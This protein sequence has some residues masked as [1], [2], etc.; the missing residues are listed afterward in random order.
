MGKDDTGER[1]E[2]LELDQHPT[3]H[4]FYVASQ[5]HP[6][7]K[8]RPGKPTPL[9]LGFIL[10]SGRKLDSYLTSRAT[11]HPSP[12]ST[13]VKAMSLAMDGLKLN[14]ASSP[15]SGAAAQLASL[16]QLQGGVGSSSSSSTTAQKGLFTLPPQ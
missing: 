4:P 14:G 1:M 11:P 5:F 9:F 2:V 3:G 8:T 6:E 12:Q 13:P 7:F 10:A 16:Q 15:V